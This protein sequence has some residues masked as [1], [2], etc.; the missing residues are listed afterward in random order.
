[1]SLNITQVDC[2]SYLLFIEMPITYLMAN[3]KFYKR[4]LLRLI[5]HVLSL[6]F[7]NLKL[8]IVTNSK[9]IKSNSERQRNDKNP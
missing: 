2:P 3:L 1:M 4:K 7:G 8:E 9:E 5:E 6:K